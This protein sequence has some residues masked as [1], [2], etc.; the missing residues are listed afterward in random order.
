[1]IILTGGAGFIGSVVLAKLNKEGIDDIIIVDNLGK[2]DKWK[3]L[4]GKHFSDFIHKTEFLPKLVNLKSIDAI[5]HLGAC[6]STT[7]TDADYLM[8]NNFNFTKELMDFAVQKEIKFIYASSAATYGDG[9]LGYSDDDKTTRILKPLNMYGF[10]KQLTD[11][12]YLKK[13]KD[14]KIVGLKFFN[15]F[16]PNEYHKKDMRSMVIKSYEQIIKDGYVKLFKSENPKYKDGEQ[17]RDFIYVKDVVDVVFWFLKNEKQGIYNLGSG[18]ANTWN[19]LV[20]AVFKALNKSPKIKYIDMPEEL[21]NKYQ[22]YTKAE[23]SKLRNAGYSQPFTT[24]EDAIKDYVQNYLIQ[25][26]RYL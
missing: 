26:E 2:T 22:Y 5:I 25:Q 4:R 8:K 10:S 23:M 14:K 17:K 18:V 20:N 3:N 24:L 7:E 13:Y 12:Y 1:M 9:S 16:G 6:S 15:V 19:S 21:K 11:E